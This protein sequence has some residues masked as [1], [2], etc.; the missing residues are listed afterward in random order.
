MSITCEFPMYGLLDALQKSFHL[1]QKQGCSV[2]NADTK[3][4]RRSLA[5]GSEN[6]VCRYIFTRSTS[7]R[8]HKKEVSRSKHLSRDGHILDVF[9]GHSQQAGLAGGHADLAV[10]R[11]LEQAQRTQHRARDIALPRKE[12]LI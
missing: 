5:V 1:T 7:R 4:C 6:I 10:R 12:L 9:Q 8:Q 2:S 3:A 11:L